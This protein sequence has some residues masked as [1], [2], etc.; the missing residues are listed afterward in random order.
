MVDWDWGDALPAGGT[1]G[2][3]A[4]GDGLPLGPATEIPPKVLSAEMLSCSLIRVTY[5]SEM[6]KTNASDANDALN[7][8]NYTFTGPTSIVAESVSVY[9]DSPTIVD[10]DISHNGTEQGTGNYTVEVNNAVGNNGLL[11]DPVNN[12]ASFNALQCINY[13]AEI[14]IGNEV[15]WSARNSVP[16]QEMVFN[17]Q[18][19]SGTQR[20]RFRIRGIE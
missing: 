16:Q 2:E 17:V 8:D 12:S 3:G 11:I 4:W 6:K 19:Y 18:K 5:D 1:W 14:M 7:P 10:I 13:V 20:L 9:Q 15:I